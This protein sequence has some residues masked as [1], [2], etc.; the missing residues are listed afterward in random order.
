MSLWAEIQAK[1]TQAEIAGGNYHA[2][3][4]KVNV[5]RVK[6]VPTEVGAGTILEVLGLT[7][8]N[9]LLDAIYNMSD[10]RYVKPLVEQGRL[11]LDAPLTIAS[12]QALVGTVLTQAQA[13]ALK[14]RA[15]APDPVT[16]EACQEAVLANK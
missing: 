1:C 2:I 9:A 6:L 11:R 13:D 16:W 3:A 10:F 8:G 15:E 5:G 14:A 12:L 7:T 4:A